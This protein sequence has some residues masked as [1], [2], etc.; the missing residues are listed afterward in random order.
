M[1]EENKEVHLRTL[2]VG[3]LCECGDGPLRHTTV[4][5]NGEIKETP[6]RV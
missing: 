4:N 6:I 2:R 5:P 1:V 3:L